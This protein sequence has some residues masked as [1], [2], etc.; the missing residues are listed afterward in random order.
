MDSSTA[1]ITRVAGFRAVGVTCGLK[2]SGRP[3]LALILS[4]VPCSAAAV[5]TTNCIKAA[6]LLYDMELLATNTP[7][8]GVVINAGNA[9]AVTGAQGL[10]DAAT[11]AQLAEVACNLP[12]SS[13]F[14]MSTGIIGRPFAHG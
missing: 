7:L 5:F 3:D 12:A 6:P 1:A 14:V 4:E 8:R 10:A 2:K 9:N 11:M 13:M